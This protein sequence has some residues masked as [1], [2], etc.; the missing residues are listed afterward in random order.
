MFEHLSIV[1]CEDITTRQLVDLE[2]AG[3][4]VRRSS[5]AGNWSTYKLLM[6]Q[7]GLPD[8]LWDVTCV[9][10]DVNNQPQHRLLGGEK[11]PLLPQLSPLRAEDTTKYLTPYH[12][13]EENGARQTLSHFHVAPLKRLYGDLITTQS[14]ALLQH[15]DKLARVF[16]IVR[17]YR[18]ELLGR[19]VLPCGCM[20]KMESH[21]AFFTA[22]CVHNEARVNFKDLAASAMGTLTELERLVFD[23]HGYEPQGGPL[24]TFEL[25][26]ASFYLWAHWQFG[27]K[28]IYELSG[29][30]MIGY[31][32]KPAFIQSIHKVLELVGRHAPDLVP[33]RIEAKIV[34]V[35]LFRFGYPQQCEISRAVMSAHEAIRDIQAV[36]RKSLGTRDIHAACDAAIR[37]ILPIVRE[38]GKKWDLFHD[39]SKDAFFSQHDLAAMG[40]EMQICDGYL[41]VPFSTMRKLLATMPN[42]ERQLYR[43]LFEQTHRTP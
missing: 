35:T 22:K 11:W 28:T 20:V 26:V 10:R 1:P 37:G 12:W 27:D 18:P 36:K 9:H 2:K 5:H 3:H 15:R 14:R 13:T 19:Y 40:G 4:C 32:T 38:H 17:I 21:G 39:P 25:V 8:C 7:V 42:N 6:S 43:K 23:S 29:P 30:D 41:D 34:P 31:A 24:Y 16:E 33:K